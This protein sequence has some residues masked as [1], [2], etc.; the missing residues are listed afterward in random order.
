MLIQFG[1]WLVVPDWKCTK[2][3]RA[4]RI[5][6]AAYTLAVPYLGSQEGYI[7]A[8][9]PHRRLAI[10]LRRDG[11]FRA[12]QWYEDIEDQQVWLACLNEDEH[13]RAVIENWRSRQE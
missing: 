1:D 13:S 9:Q 4:A 12:T 8:D 11:S 7:Y 2:A 3:E 10:E 6:T 5:Q